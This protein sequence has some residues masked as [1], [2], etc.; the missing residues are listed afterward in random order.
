MDIRRGF[1]RSSRLEL[2]D[3][4]CLIEEYVASRHRSR[5]SLFLSLSE[6][7]NVLDC[8]AITSSVEHADYIAISC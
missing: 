2:P 8:A 6:Y 1:V 7:L 4:T 5:S 3:R